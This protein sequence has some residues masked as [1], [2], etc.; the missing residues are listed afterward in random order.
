M[1]PPST[2]MAVW[3]PA[4]MAGVTGTRFLFGV[5]YI[6]A[7][8]IYYLTGPFATYST[9]DNWF[10]MGKL[11]L[12]PISSFV[13][14]LAVREITRVNAGGRRTIWYNPAA[15]Q[16][17]SISHATGAAFLAIV[18]TIFAVIYEFSWYTNFTEWIILGVMTLVFIVA[19]IVLYYLR[20]SMKKIDARTLRIKVTWAFVWQVIVVGAMNVFI[21]LA[22]LFRLVGPPL[23]FW[24]GPVL[25]DDFWVGLIELGFVLLITILTVIVVNIQY[26]RAKGWGMAVKGVVTG[27]DRTPLSKTEFG[28]E[29]PT[30]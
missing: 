3:W 28:E 24:A 18:I 9:A 23:A 5:L 7:L 15:P 22:S 26:I 30:E 4:M 25:I 27:E 19:M 6:I 12:A 20:D 29:E 10:F 2:L 14:W 11:L 8:A 16:F 1:Y 13:A 21:I 17:V